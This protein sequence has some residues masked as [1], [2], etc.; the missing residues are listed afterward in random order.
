VRPSRVIRRRWSRR[1]PGQHPPFWSSRLRGGAAPLWGWFEAPAPSRAFRFRAGSF[2]GPY[3]KRMEPAG[4]TVLC[5]HVAEAR[6][7]FAIV[8]RTE[9]ERLRIVFHLGGLRHFVT[10]RGVWLLCASRAR[11]GRGARSTV[12]ISVAATSEERIASGCCGHLGHPGQVRVQCVAT[13]ALGQRRARAWLNT[14]GS[15]S[16]PPREAKPSPVV[17]PSAWATVNVLGSSRLRR[18]RAALE[19]VRHAGAIARV[20]IW[21]GLIRAA[22]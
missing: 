5:H 12:L 20:S 17:A 13:R 11:H 8:I 10:D 3:N 22:V 6:G 1:T 19:V 2:A 9:E 18:C 4:P 14:A 7:S 15:R 21:R 16:N